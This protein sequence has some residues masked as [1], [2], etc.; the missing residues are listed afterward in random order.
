[1]QKLAIALIVDL[2]RLKS[3]LE[4][5]LS[6]YLDV[7]LSSFYKKLNEAF[8]AQKNQE[9]ELG[10]E[11]IKKAHR[12]LY[13]ITSS[14]N[15]LFP[16]LYQPETINEVDKKRQVPNI[17]DLSHVIYNGVDPNGVCHW[18]LSSSQPYSRSNQLLHYFFPDRQNDSRTKACIYACSTC[19]VNAVPLF[20]QLFSPND[21]TLALE[22]T[23]ESQVAI[24]NN[25]SIQAILKDPK[26][27]LSILT[28]S[29]ALN[30]VAPKTVKETEIV[31][32]QLQNY[33]MLAL[34]RINPEYRNKLPLKRKLEC[35]IKNFF[36]FGQEIGEERLESVQIYIGDLCTVLSEEHV[37]S[38][39]KALD[40]LKKNYENRHQQA[41]RT[42]KSDLYTIMKK[43]FAGPISAIINQFTKA[44]QKQFKLALEEEKCKLESE[45]KSLQATISKAE[46]EKIE[47]E[48]KLK[49]SE[50]QRVR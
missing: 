21:R 11:R 12:Y 20:S 47:M 17:D 3:E 7:M 14:S 32:Q 30:G 36:K 33:Y 48:A 46:Q 16:Y 9:H 8:E 40:D 22:N 44:D 15:S 6:D 37:D 50:A 10:V 19:Q 28:Q 43:A 5:N 4:N 27:S 34:V 49:E 45:V 39:N 1:M 26:K 31:F 24:K 42:D 18:K 35:L 23:P 25:L 41:Q 38:I 29:K 13:A 2:Q